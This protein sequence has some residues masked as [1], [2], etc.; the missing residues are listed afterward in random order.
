MNERPIDVASP[1]T[2]PKETTFGTWFAP[3]QSVP[4]IVV[5]PGIDRGTDP[6]LCPE[7]FVGLHDHCSTCECDHNE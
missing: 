5:G 6:A 1:R 4:C 3:I 7:C 2:I